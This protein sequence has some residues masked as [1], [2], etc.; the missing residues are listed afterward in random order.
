LKVVVVA[1]STVM[2]VA[3]QSLV[4]PMVLA[5]KE[6]VDSFR[7]EQ[8]VGL[9]A[10]MLSEDLEEVGVRTDLVEVPAGVEDILVELQVKMCIIRVEEE[11]DLSTVGRIRLTQKDIKLMAM[12]TLL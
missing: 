3:V 4:K 6:E 5:G 8:V 2:D 1:D 10:I 12:V 7:V 11:V 9:S